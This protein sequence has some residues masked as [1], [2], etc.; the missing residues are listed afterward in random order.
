MQRFGQNGISWEPP[1]GEGVEP[2]ETAETRRCFHCNTRVWS[3]Y[4]LTV[5]PKQQQ[6]DL[7]SYPELNDPGSSPDRRP[8]SGIVRNSPEARR[9]WLYHAHRN[10]PC[11]QHQQS[12]RSRSAFAGRT[13]SH[14]MRSRTAALDRSKLHRVAGLLHTLSRRCS[15]DLDARCI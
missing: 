11:T 6:F 12:N 8:S 4:R 5:G 2:N 7:N 15:P 9:P 10:R 3:S 1:G 13:L 14:I